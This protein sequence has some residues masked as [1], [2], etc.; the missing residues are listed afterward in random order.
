MFD[1]EINP[2]TLAIGA[3]TLGWVRFGII[4]MMA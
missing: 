1:Y 4:L 2:L 3:S